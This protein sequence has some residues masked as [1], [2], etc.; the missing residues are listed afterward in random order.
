MALK[1][2]KSL[3]KNFILSLDNIFFILVAILPFSF[4][5][6]TLI[7]NSILF[8]L[9]LIFLLNFKNFIKFNYLFEIEF[10]ILFLFCFYLLINSFLN[11]I[12]VEKLIKS[13]SILRFPILIIVVLYFFKKVTDQK[14]NLW[15]NLNI[16]FIF[17]ISFDLLFQYFIG[18]NTLGYLPGMCGENYLKDQSV[19]TRYSGFFNDELIM[20]GYLST[21]I[22]SIILL[23]NK[24]KKYPLFITAIL[25]SF[26]Y[27]LIMITGERSAT[28]TILL[29]IF[30]I[31]LQYKTKFKTKFISTILLITFSLLMVFLN[32]HLK[33]RYIDFFNHDMQK[34]D[35]LSS[36]EKILTTP[37]GLHIQKSL[38][39]F[40]EKP[41]IGHGIRSFRIKCDNY[42]LFIE[43]D[44]KKHRACSTHPH[45]LIM[46]LLSEQGI[47]GFILFF[48][49]FFIL[50]K[51]SFQN[52]GFFSRN[53]TLIS[54]RAL[55]FVIIF[56]PK[57][58]GSIFSSINA[59]MIW[60]CISLFV[61]EVYS[62]KI[63][64]N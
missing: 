59:T 22:F 50:F 42:E 36:Y 58:V 2:F 27:I 7:L 9:F 52:H 38:K 6:G 5:F 46:E 47:I 43:R 10:K 8:I 11:E 29:T 1:N 37:W 35:H 44:E 24:I 48:T 30:F 61:L 53:F 13:F 31:F 40:I 20:G 16:L 15:A 45:N 34:N 28:L 21:I 64:E 62:K 19:C 56:I 33:G 3:N 39:L 49:F 57:P 25:I 12:S 32:P 23:I 18:K 41:L 17:I 63:N 51:K 26:L 14:K 60:F 54:L 55:V 4:L